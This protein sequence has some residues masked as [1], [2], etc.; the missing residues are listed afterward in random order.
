MMKTINDMVDQTTEPYYMTL[1]KNLERRVKMLEQIN[2]SSIKVLNA[3]C[4]RCGKVLEDSGDV[5][6]NNPNCEILPRIS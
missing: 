2:S 3:Q 4:D 1:I 6:C 5:V